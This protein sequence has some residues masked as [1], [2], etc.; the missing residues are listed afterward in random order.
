MYTDTKHQFS[1]KLYHVSYYIQRG[2]NREYHLLLKSL[3]DILICEHC[4]VTAKHALVPPL[5]AK[6]RRCIHSQQSN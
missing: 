5:A 1:I 2:A 3:K 4:N 6:E